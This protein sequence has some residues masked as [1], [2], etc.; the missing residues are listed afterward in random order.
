MLA[1]TLF[2]TTSWRLIKQVLAPFWFAAL[3][4]PLAQAQSVRDGAHDFDWEFGTW[5]TKVRVRPPLSAAETWTEFSG[6]SIVQPLSRGRSNTVDLDVRSGERRI[7]GVSLRLY[8]PQTHQWSLNFASMRDGLLTAPVSGSFAEGRGTFFGKDTVDGRLVQVRFVISDITPTSARFEQSYSGD[9]G[10]TWL[11]NWIATDTRAGVPAGKPE[12]R[13]AELPADLVRA[14]AAY[15]R[16][17][18]NNDTGALADLMTEDYLLVNSDSSLENKAQY[19]A[20]FHLPGFRI[21]P[22]VMKEPLAR[23]DGDTALTGGLLPLTWT[24]DGARHHRL[25]RIAHL[26]IRSGNRWRVAYTQLTR[27]PE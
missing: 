5:E 24:Q 21:E 13:R 10:K 8:D 27:V 23:I 1:N 14:V 19:L 2:G 22:Y 17:T 4:A 9:G 20:D 25:L 7:E 15:D 12:S 11:V 26:W 3:L 18:T 6:T 16:A